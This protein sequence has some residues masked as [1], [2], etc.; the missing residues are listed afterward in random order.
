VLPEV[1]VKNGRKSSKVSR[2]EVVPAST[3]PTDI[4]NSTD[5]AS[6]TVGSTE[7]PKPK[8]RSRAPRETQVSTTDNMAATDKPSADADTGATKK[9][10]KK[11]GSAA[12]QLTLF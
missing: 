3:Q 8:R 10:K 5:E 12:E 9:T 1:P 6:V 2:S 11:D 7:E 4:L